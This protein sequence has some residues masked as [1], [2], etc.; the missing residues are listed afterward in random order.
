M[1]AGGLRRSA[2]TTREREALAWLYRFSDWERGVGWSREA[3]PEEE[4][5]LGRTRA[6]LDLAGAPDRR[7][8]IVHVAGTKGKGSTIAYLE[9]IVRAAGWQMGAYTQPHLHS[10]RERIR[11][12]GRPVGS[13]AFAAGV[14]R[15][16]GLVDQLVKL[17]PEA[18]A[19]TTFELT[20]VLAI[21]L[22]AEAGVDLAIAEVGLGGRLDATNALETDLAV[23]ARIGLDHRQILGRTL[24]EIAGEK[25][26][27]AR[28]GQRVLSARQRPSARAVVTAHCRE[29]GADSRVIRP[30]HVAPGADSDGSV[31]GRLASG[32]RFEA[33]LGLATLLEGVGE[34]Q[35]QNAALAVAAAEALVPNGLPLTIDAVERGLREAWLPARLELVRVRP[36]VLIDAA[37]N[38]DSARALADELRR[39]RNRPLWLVLGIL[40]DKDAPAILRVLLPLAD[41]VVVVTP[42]SPRALPA[43]SLA[44]ACRKV[45][46]AEVVVGS[47]VGAA[48]E[49]ARLRAGR[50]GAV[51]VAGSFA[52]ASEARSSL[53]LEGVVTAEARRAWIRG[54]G[55]ET[56]ETGDRR[57]ESG[58]WPEVPR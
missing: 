22:F 57:Q 43:E 45:S 3:A 28:P 31:V 47:S 30:L 34:H 1:T 21:L 39:W 16:R 51:A 18:G 41:G 26:A 36:R 9:A 20:T 56:E 52:T 5:K 11:L 14:D 19:P 48:I 27:I 50:D 29:I 40:R 7:M 2:L 8:R 12:D 46:T 6:L 24:A 55:L 38:V 54:G 15:L 4:W 37:H 42:T 53:G 32:E 17:H 44:A 13:A 58:E 25:V 35:R 23:I 33:R 49:L 10:F